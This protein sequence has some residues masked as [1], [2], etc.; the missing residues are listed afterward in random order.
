MVRRTV[1]EESE[2]RITTPAFD[3]VGEERQISDLARDG[4]KLQVVAIMLCRQKVSGVCVFS[5]LRPKHYP[6][7]T[8]AA[9][10]HRPVANL[11]KTRPGRR[12]YCSAK[13]RRKFACIAPTQFGIYLNCFTR[14]VA[15]T[16]DILS[17]K[18]VK[19]AKRI[20]IRRRIFYD[21]FADDR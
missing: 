15:P 21:P 9:K 11:K 12:N 18:R 17:L 2:N 8:V 16:F 6:V 14:I 1:D 20:E 4:Q 5:R 13:R 10:N 19:V 3:A 7:N